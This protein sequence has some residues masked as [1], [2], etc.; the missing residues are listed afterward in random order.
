MW[1][2]CRYVRVYDKME[3]QP[4][5]EINPEDL[6]LETKVGEGEFGAVYKGRWNKTTVAI[7][8]LRRSDAVAL[9][10]FRYAIIQHWHTSFIAPEKL[11]KKCVL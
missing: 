10:D 4:E 7:K 11:A 5:F 3:L 2:S 1:R 9:G 6:Q 8:V